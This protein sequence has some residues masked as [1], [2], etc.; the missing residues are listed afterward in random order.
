MLTFNRTINGTLNRTVAAL[1]LATTCCLAFSTAALAGV[2]FYEHDDY[3]GRSFTTAR[4][5]G[6]FLNVGFN[7][8]ASSI[9]VTGSRWEVCEDLRFEGRCRVLRQGSY[10]SLRAMG[11]NDRI[12]SVRPVGASASVDEER[13][14]PAAPEPSA[15]RRRAGERLFEAPVSEVRV[16]QGRVGQRCW[17]ERQEGVEGNRPQGDGRGRVLGARTSPD[18]RSLE[19]HDVQR[20]EAANGPAEV[21]HWDVRYRFRGQLHGVQLTRPPGA[22]VTVNGRGEPRE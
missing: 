22:T 21:L 3:Q 2:T 7:D 11:M 5:V 9:V 13:F 12:S 18:G 1:S 19:W 17:T 15:W 14:G 16:V 20:C 6:N 8:R 10:P 4:R